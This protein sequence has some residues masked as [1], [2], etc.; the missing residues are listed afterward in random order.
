[1]FVIGKNEKNSNKETEPQHGEL[2]IEE[3]SFD[4]GSK[5]YNILRYTTWGNHG[6]AWFTN[7]S[8]IKTLGEAKKSLKTK[9]NAKKRVSVKFLDI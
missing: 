3:V 5:E 7:E 2:K 9:R 1:M 6:C 4:D 8:H